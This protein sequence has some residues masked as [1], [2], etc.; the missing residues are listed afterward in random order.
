MLKTDE[1]IK[2]QS[3]V[4]NTLFRQCLAA[5]PEVQKAEFEQTQLHHADHCED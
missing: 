4:Q 3:M 2:F 1:Q 5:V